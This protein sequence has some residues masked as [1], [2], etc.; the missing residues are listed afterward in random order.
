MDTLLLIPKHLLLAETPY[1]Y[2]K[3]KKYQKGL[4]SQ[5]SNSSILMVL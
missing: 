2:L 3:L 5:E 4:G 1:S